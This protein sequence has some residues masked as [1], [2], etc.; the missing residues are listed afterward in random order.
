M[1]LAIFKN[2]PNAFSEENV[3]TL[4]KNKNLKIPPL[5]YFEDNTHLE[6]RKILRDQN[7]AWKNK[8]KKVDKSARLKK[9]EQPIITGGEDTLKI[10]QLEKELLEAKQK[11]EEIS[12]N[13]IESNDQPTK[14]TIEIPQENKASNS[15][16]IQKDEVS[17]KNKAIQNK[18]EE[19]DDNV[20]VSAISDIDDSKIEETKLDGQ[21]KKGLET[22]HV[23]LLTLFFILL[24]GLLVVISR[25][26]A[27]ERNQQLKSFTDEVGSQNENKAD[28]TIKNNEDVGFQGSESNQSASEGSLNQ[29]QGNLSDKKNYL[30]IADDEDVKKL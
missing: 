2:N 30:P 8:L 16:T 3:N 21:D 20:F 5:S 28:G 19:K 18:L 7:N 1:V 14:K 22:I 26:K 13:N 25:R 4:I 27:S 17:S 24:F 6:A 10:K 9:N 23:L 29:K 12:K 11:I 15:D